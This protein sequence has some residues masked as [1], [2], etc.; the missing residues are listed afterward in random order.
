MVQI[1]AY[2]G[3]RVMF[4]AETPLYSD[5]DTGIMIMTGQ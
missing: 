4:I 2:L 5:Y 1:P 3:F